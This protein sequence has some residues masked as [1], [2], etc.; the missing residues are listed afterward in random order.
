MGPWEGEKVSRKGCDMANSFYTLLSIIIISELS[1]CT[2]DDSRMILRQLECQ[3]LFAH[4]SNLSSV[5][6]PIS[7]TRKGPD[8]CCG[9]DATFEVFIVSE[10]IHHANR[11]LHIMWFYTNNGCLW[12]QWY[13]YFHEVKD[14]MFHSTRPSWVGWS[15]LSFTE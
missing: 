4:A 8:N 3:F 10:A 13:K 6:L 5:G 2:M 11:K 7:T 14:E 1:I 12:V 9:E 15:I